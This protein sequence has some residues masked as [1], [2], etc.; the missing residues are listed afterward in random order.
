MTL[1]LPIPATAEVIIIFGQITKSHDDGIMTE[2]YLADSEIAFTV[3]EGGSK[4]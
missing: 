2:V 3:L 1:F 4:D